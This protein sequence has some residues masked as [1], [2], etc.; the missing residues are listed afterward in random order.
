M[1]SQSQIMWDEV[2]SFSSQSLQT[3]VGYVVGSDGHMH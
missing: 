1:A 3:A 2:S